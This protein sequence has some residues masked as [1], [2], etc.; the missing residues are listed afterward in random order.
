MTGGPARVLDALRRAEGRTCS[1]ESL[2]ARY[3]VSR[4]QVWKDVEALRARG[5]RIGAA[6][7]GG[8]RLEEIPDH[9]YPDEILAG[10]ALHFPKYRD[11]RVQRC[12]HQMAAVCSA[13]S[14]GRRLFVSNFTY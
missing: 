14:R 13:D 6:P 2:S 4:T 8:Y 3:G 11:R 9:L 1:G 7:G 5:Y 12:Q 10:L